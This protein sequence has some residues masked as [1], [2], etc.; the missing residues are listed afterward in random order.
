MPKNT[1]NNNSLV[2]QLIKALN[3][4]LKNRADSVDPDSEI[5]MQDVLSDISL[6]VEK[7]RRLNDPSI[8]K[9]IYANRDKNKIRMEVLNR[10]MA[11]GGI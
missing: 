2:P 10:I 5:F 11:M 4:S 1:N 7:V 6:E 3:K 9:S 8:W